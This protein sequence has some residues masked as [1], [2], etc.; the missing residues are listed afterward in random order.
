MYKR[1]L[2]KDVEYVRLD[3]LVLPL[4]FL[5]ISLLILLR[6][7]GGMS[8]PRVV[9][10]GLATVCCLLVDKGGIYCMLA[11]LAPLSTGISATY[12]AA[13]ALVILLLKQR[14]M[15]LHFAGL[16]SMLGVLVLELLSA[17]RG[18]FDLVEYLRFVGMFAV[19]F[20][21]MLDGSD[22]YN[23]EGMVRAFILGYCVA[24]ASIM[25]QMMSQYSLEAIFTM[26]VRLGDTRDLVGN[27]TEG[28][29]VS[30][31]PNGLGTLCLLTGLMCLA[32]YRKK[33]KLR[34]MA[35]FAV[36]VLLGVMT[37]SRTFVLTFAAGMVGWLFLGGSGWRTAAKRLLI[38]VAGLVGLL[39]VAVL[40]VPEYLAGIVLRFQVSDLGNGRG[41]IMAHYFEEILRSAD[42]IIFGVGMQN[43]AEKLDY[44]MSAHNAIQEILV[45]WGVLGLIAVLILFIGVF[46]NSRTRSPR[47]KWLQY[48][49]ALM[50]LVCLQ[51]GQGFSVESNMLRLMAAVSVLGLR[52]E[53][54]EEKK[55]GLVH[56]QEFDSQD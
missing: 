50:Y 36:T 19:T 9:F 12:I 33:S 31:N 16:M 30:Y 25:G 56:V 44:E 46:R 28:M 6:D 24:M 13:I 49:P 45:M 14:R 8:V 37:Q 55:E 47:S 35:I 5:C 34:Y 48:L 22:E 23:H 7:V 15:Y 29:L 10:I 32:M 3:K 2:Q 51:A 39:M 17:L 38:C 20:L 54:D 4:C 40:V 1:S 27:G 41:E 53:P 43:Y 52:L 26:G 21:Y 42:R 11:F 18:R